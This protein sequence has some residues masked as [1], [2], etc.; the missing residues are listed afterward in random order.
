LSLRRLEGEDVRAWQLQR[1]PVDDALV[2]ALA[3]RGE[4]R[5]IR[6]GMIRSGMLASDH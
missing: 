2:A 3:W 4:E 1:L 6:L 5:R